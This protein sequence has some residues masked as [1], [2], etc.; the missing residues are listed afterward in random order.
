MRKTSLIVCF[1]LV[2]TICSSIVNSEAN[3]A[4]ESDL[5]S[6]PSSGPGPG[7]YTR[8]LF[9]QEVGTHNYSVL[10]TELNDSY[11]SVLPICGDGRKSECVESLE[12]REATNQ[13]WKKA[14]L[15]PRLN[16]N[17][18]GI[19]AFRWPDNALQFYGD[20][21]ANQSTYRPAG[22]TSRTWKL[23]DAT[24]AGGNEYLLSVTV[25]DLHETGRKNFNQSLSA[26]LRA[27]KWITPPPY[28]KWDKTENSIVEFNLPTE[29][30]FRVN[31]NLGFLDGK[32]SNWYNGRLSNPA[33]TKANG[34]LSISAKAVTVPIGGTDFFTCSSLTDKKR[35][36][37]Q[38][39]T[40]PG[41]D[42]F[43]GPMCND[44]SGSSLGTSS[45]DANAFKAFE[46]FESDLKEFG[47]N[48]Y[49]SFEATSNAFN[50]C[51]T[52]N[53]AG[54]VSSDAMI[55]T[56]EPPYFNS[57]TSQLS[58]RIAS[59]HQDKSGTLN[60][61]KFHLVISQSVAECLWQLNPTE[62][63]TAVVQVVYSDGQPIV[64]TS[65]LKTESGWVYINVDNFT[66]S[67]PTLN[68]TLS[69]KSPAEKVVNAP[70]SAPVIKKR[71]II[72]IK[73]KSTKKITGI[74]PKCP[75]GFKK[76]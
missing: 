59:T 10:P 5:I 35:D 16:P 3:G 9:Q 48:S 74:N 37:F 66:F 15:T 70:S 32:L 62:L 14:E 40:F 61:G 11:I 30:E 39:R 50:F 60:R 54:F 13:E 4:T 31:I 38:S 41:E 69:N 27:V 20:V 68:V 67:A 24:H 1:S 47:K 19:Q 23:A 52:N 8:L 63:S 65:T 42:F 53:I 51:K 2:L 72:C 22:A 26:S 76:K 45:A 58:Y 44:R 46:A 71:T 33:V 36:Y 43:T 21:T 7:G 73:G 25:S 6:A 18:S 12:Y 64:G 75:T 56:K 17:M 55:Y 34:I 29:I 57:S 28:G 49:W